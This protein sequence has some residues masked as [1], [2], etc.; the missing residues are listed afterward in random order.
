[1]VDFLA[2]IPQNGIGIIEVKEFHY[3]VTDV[4]PGKVVQIDAIFGEGTRYIMVDQTM[5]IRERIYE[6]Y[7]GDYE[8]PFV[9]VLKSR[10]IRLKPNFL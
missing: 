9:S 4:Y 2:E 6:V 5:G 3:L 1:M 8:G 7:D 10:Y